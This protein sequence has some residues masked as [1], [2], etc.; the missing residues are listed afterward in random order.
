MKPERSPR[1]P[2]RYRYRLPANSARRPAR[3]RNARQ[4]A[5]RP[6][7]FLTLRLSSALAIWRGRRPGILAPPLVHVFESARPAA[8][9]SASAATTP[10]SGQPVRGSDHG[11]RPG[12]PDFPKHHRAEADADADLNQW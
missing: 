2:A 3:Y 1:W 6:T 5:A 10:T 8:A 12:I 4:A 11:V 7:T 9:E